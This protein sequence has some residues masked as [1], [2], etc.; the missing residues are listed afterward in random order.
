MDLISDLNSVPE[1]L[2]DCSDNEIDNESNSQLNMYLSSTKVGTI[3]KEMM[4]SQNEPDY[5][6]VYKDLLVHHEIYD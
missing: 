5:L 1:S 3:E 2:I 4:K 6:P